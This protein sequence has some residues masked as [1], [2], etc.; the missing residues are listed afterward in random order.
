MAE[1]SYP[2]QPGAILHDAIM[3]AFR[4]HGS[5]FEAWLNENGVKPVIARNA[6]FGLTQGPKGTEL[7]SRLI[8]GAGADLVRAGY[9]SRLYRHLEEARRASDRIEANAPRHRERRA[10]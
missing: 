7:L 2:Y 3:G 5:S 10:S 8:E 1:L 6:T 9:M 4:T